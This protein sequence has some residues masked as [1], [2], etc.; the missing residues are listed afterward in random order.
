MNGAPD[1]NW[2]DYLELTVAAMLASLARGA[3]WQDPVTGKFSWS[4]L[5]Q[6]LA[7]A[8]TIAIGAAAAQEK[9]GF[10]PP[11]TAFMAVV[12]A[13]IGIPFFVVMFR[14]VATSLVQAYVRGGKE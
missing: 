11:I 6:S 9:W 8:G 10:P 7:T 4:L 3:S 1:P 2:L 12:G 14:S 13:L 5:A